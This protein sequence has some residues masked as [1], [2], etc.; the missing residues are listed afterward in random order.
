MKRRSI[1]V[2]NPSWTKMALSSSSYQITKVDIVLLRYF[3]EDDFRP[4]MDR[5]IAI[6]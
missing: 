4:C 5:D 2:Q 6:Y 3:T 1:I